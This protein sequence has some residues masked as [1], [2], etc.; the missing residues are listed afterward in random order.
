M[1]PLMYSLLLFSSMM[2]GA[3]FTYA[4]SCFPSFL[5]MLASFLVLSNWY[6][7]IFLCSSFSTFLLY[8]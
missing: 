2:F 6:A 5:M 8:P 1:F 3:P 4:V 7:L